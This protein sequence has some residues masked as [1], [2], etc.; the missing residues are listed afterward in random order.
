METLESG[1]FRHRKFLY[2]S[3]IYNDISLAD[4]I[5]G[6]LALVHTIPEDLLESSERTFR[7]GFCLG[8]TDAETGATPDT[9]CMINFER[10][11]VRDNL[12][13]AD[14]GT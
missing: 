13:G 8:R 3:Y 4:S 11:I 1:F 12:H 9:F 7:E 10:I 6:L 14:I 2:Y 5:P